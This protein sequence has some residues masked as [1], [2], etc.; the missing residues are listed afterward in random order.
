MYLTFDSAKVFPY[1]DGKVKKN[2]DTYQHNYD[3]LFWSHVSNP[4]HVLCGLR[5]TKTFQTNS[6]KITNDLSS[7]LVEIS[8]QAKVKIR[9]SVVYLDPKNNIR[10]INEIFTGNKYYENATDPGE[11]S[12]GMKLSLYVNQ[13]IKDIKNTKTKDNPNKK[14]LLSDVSFNKDDYKFEDVVTETPYIS[15]QR[16]KH[17]VYYMPV[18]NSFMI[19]VKQIEP[20]YQNMEFKTIIERLNRE[21][22]EQN[23]IV[24]EFFDECYYNDTRRD[25]TIPEI[26]YNLI[27]NGIVKEQYI[28]QSGYGGKNKMLPYY[29][30]LVNRAP[31]KI[32]DLNGDI[33]VK[34]DVEI[35][36]KLIK[37]S[38]TILDGGV[39]KISKIVSEREFDETSIETFNDVVLEKVYV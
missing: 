7:K 30:K 37:S 31:E 14:S 18:Y 4:L 15:W 17:H 32:V 21:Y 26:Y 20:N 39:L 10:Y 1:D 27:C 13:K 8:K 36:S 11:K 16:F 29:T 25:S 34:I 38:C 35:L 2:T 12:F 9:N 5:P 6:Y 22:Y 19:M 23:K 3:T 28:H 33:V 24:L